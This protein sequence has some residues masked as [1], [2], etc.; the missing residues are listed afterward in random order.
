MIERVEGG[1]D[2]GLRI[3]FEKA[4]EIRASVTPAETIR[5][6][7]GQAA[8]YPRSNLVRYHFHI[9]RNRDEHALFILK[10][11]FEI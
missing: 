6:E 3:H 2:C 5:A 4:P 10:Q 9:I 11:R 7:R 1:D 8:R